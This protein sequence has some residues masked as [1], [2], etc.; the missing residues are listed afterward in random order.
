MESAPWVWLVLEGHEW[1]PMD[2]LARYVLDV[3]IRSFVE[4]IG[5][6]IVN[7][8]LVKN[9]GSMIGLGFGLDA[10]THLIK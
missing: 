6:H 1:Q 2:S 5:G 3:A 7:N 10:P 4:E 8:E 9:S